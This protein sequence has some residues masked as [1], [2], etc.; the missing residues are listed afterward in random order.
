MAKKEENISIHISRVDSGS[1][2]FFI[3]GKTPLIVNRVSEKAKRELLLPR[4]K[5]A[6][7]KAQNLKHDPYSEFNSSPYIDQ[8]PKAPTLLVALSAWFKKGMANAAMDVPGS[9]KSQIGRL[10]WVEGERIPLYGLPEMCMSVVRS[11]DMNR[12]PD[13]RTR[14]IIPAWATH[15]TVSYIKPMLNDQSIINLLTS[16]GMCQGAGDWRVGKGS[17]TYGCYEIV[18]KDDPRYVKLLKAGRKE[19]LKAMDEPGFFDEETE[20]L[21][22]WYLNEVKARGREDQ[23]MKR[24]KKAGKATPVANGRLASAKG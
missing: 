7:D 17:G 9:N 4:K 6:A 21:F 15:F 16:A 13:V 11:S 23:T 1:I 22:H 18:G 24:T 12:T 19:Q 8:N 14:C 10:C 3:L 20:E 5:T 2:G